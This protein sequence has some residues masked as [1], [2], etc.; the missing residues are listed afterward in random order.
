MKIILKLLVI[1]LVTISN[2]YAQDIHYPT[3]IIFSQPQL[4]DSNQQSKFFYS[5]N[6]AGDLFPVRAVVPNA[7]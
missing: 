7:R 5:W 3:P 1:F 2:I 6:W 4:V